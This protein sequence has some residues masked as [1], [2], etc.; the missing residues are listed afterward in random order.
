MIHAEISIR[1]N[2]SLADTDSLQTFRGS[3]KLKV[4]LLKSWSLNQFSALGVSSD[5]TRLQGN[6]LLA[7]P[8]CKRL[9]HAYHWG[10]QPETLGSLDLSKAQ[11]TACGDSS[12]PN[13]WHVP[14]YF[15]TSS[16]PD[17]SYSGYKIALL[18]GNILLCLQIV[19]PGN[20]NN[21]AAPPATCAKMK[22]K[23]P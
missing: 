16:L 19:P 14:F 12:R 2:Y 8:I 23:K 1:N 11:W 15:P 22:P 20:N 3:I 9:I 21:L 6:Q 4:Q 10:K 7:V 5:D 17:S 18:E 13:Y